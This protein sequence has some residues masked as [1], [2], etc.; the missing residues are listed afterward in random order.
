MITAQETV[1]CYDH[2]IL[3]SLHPLSF[4][5]MIV[6]PIFFRANAVFGCAIARLTTASWPHLPQE[7]R[8]SVRKWRLFEG[9]C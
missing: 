8:E 1:P 5:D 9:P 6:T 4:Q 2:L 7:P 3:P